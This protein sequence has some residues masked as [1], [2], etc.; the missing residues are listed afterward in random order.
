MTEAAP[1]TPTARPTFWIALTVVGVGIAACAGIE[2]DTPETPQDGLGM[3]R[4]V[5]SDLSA[6]NISEAQMRDPVFMRGLFEKLIYDYQQEINSLEQDQNYKKAFPFMQQEEPLLRKIGLWDEWQEA[7][8]KFQNFR[9]DYYS[10]LTTVERVGADF[11]ARRI[12]P[13]EAYR[14]LFALSQER[15][16]FMTEHNPR[17]ILAELNSLIDRVTEL[18]YPGRRVV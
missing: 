15:V 13:E 1:R 7:R 3:G 12:T 5:L 17:E 18:K 14:R 16:R 10:F 9:D 6:L 2:Q 4:F 8:H 11:E